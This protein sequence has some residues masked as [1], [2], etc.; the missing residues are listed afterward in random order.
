M[1][2]QE[3]PD[4]GL[5]L[6]GTKPQVSDIEDID[7]LGTDEEHFR[8]ANLYDLATFVMHKFGFGCRKQNVIIKVAGGAAPNHVTH[9]KIYINKI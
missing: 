3:S 9:V 4:Q 6:S 1:K 8:G 5:F 7:K 2:S